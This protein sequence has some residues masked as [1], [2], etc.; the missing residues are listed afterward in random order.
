MLEGE[1]PLTLHAAVLHVGQLDRQTWRFG[2]AF[3]AAAE[4]DGARLYHDRELAFLRRR[5]REE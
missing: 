2:A 1:V 4:E 5:R 3:T